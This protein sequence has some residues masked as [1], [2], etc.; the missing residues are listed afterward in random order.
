MLNEACWSK[1]VRSSDIVAVGRDGEFGTASWVFGVSSDGN[2]M[3]GLAWTGGLHSLDD[4]SGGRVVVVRSVMLPVA[5]V[6]ICRS[7]VLVGIHQSFDVCKTHCNGFDRS[8]QGWL[9]SPV[10]GAP[11]S[12]PCPYR[13]FCACPSEAASPRDPTSARCNAGDRKVHTDRGL[14]TRML[15][16]RLEH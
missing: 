2:V 5:V 10:E 6:F 11:W 16:R 4:T 1:D 12:D 3:A 8:R 13:T 7:V 9:R 14:G 15:P